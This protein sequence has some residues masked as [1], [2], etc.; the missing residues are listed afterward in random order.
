MMLSGS[1]LVAFF[2]TLLLAVRGRA[3]DFCEPS[4]PCWP[5]EAAW[6]D[7]NA[8]VGGRLVNVGAAAADYGKCYEFGTNAFSLANDLNGLCYQGHNCAMQDCDGAS[9]ENGGLFNFPSFSVTAEST[10]DVSA[11]VLF[12]K[13]HNLKL[14]VRTSGH[15]Y[16]GSNGGPGSLR[17]FTRKLPSFSKNGPVVHVDSCGTQTVDAVKVG[18]GELWGEVYG[19]VGD[20]RHIV[21]GGGL[22]V[23]SA[24]GWLG[25]SGLSST[26]RKY[27]LGVDN[28][29]D[30]TVVLANGTVVIADNCT[31]TDLFW[32]LRGGGGG[33]FGVVTAVHYKTH[34]LQNLV[35]VRLSLTAPEKFFDTWSGLMDFWVDNSPYLDNRWGGY[36]TG[37]SLLLMFVGP[38]Q[39]A[40]DTLIDKLQAWRDT[41]SEENGKE[42]IDLDV[43]EFSSYLEYRGGAQA[44]SDPRFTDQTGYLGLDIASRLVPRQHVIDNP[45][46]VKQQLK[47]IIINAQPMFNYFLGGAMGDVDA[48][49]MGVHPAMRTAIWQIETFTP[50]ANA[51]V[52]NM[53]DGV[54]NAGSGLNHGARDEPDWRNAFWAENYPRLLSV[55][56]AVD[57]ELRFNCWHCVGYTGPE[58]PQNTDK[59]ELPLKF[60]PKDMSDGMKIAIS[61]TTLLFIVAL[62]F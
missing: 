39:D 55:K 32:A 29:L 36:W 24:G 10:A 42:T 31:N 47:D 6:D 60:V 50:V 23:A 30:F 2:G 37:T 9:Y 38:L 26:A 7:L 53:V 59:G 44:M 14:S 11:G 45:T 48:Q 58:G 8:T 41:F 13:Q 56:T 12:A 17:I 35:D 27:G 22:T 51:F 33:T 40:Q 57:P 25:G 28:V 16:S 46:Q 52:K 5:S 20:K 62:L 3:D 19:A 1:P 18:G 21:G 43:K 61:G 54:P 34:E 15:S 4:Q 49:E